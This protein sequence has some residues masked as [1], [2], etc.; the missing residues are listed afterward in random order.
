MYLDESGDHTLA[1]IDPTYPVFVLGGIIVDR[2]YARTVL[3]PRVRAFKA[4]WFGSHSIV[5]HSTDIARARNGFEGLR[6]PSFRREFLA[7]LS[8]LMAELDYLVVACLIHKNKPGI[9]LRDR[10]LNL[11]DDGLHLVV[12]RF[13]LAL[14]EQ[15]DSGLIYAEK[16]RPDLDLALDIAWE[17]LSVRGTYDLNKQRLGLINERIC[18]LS[19][20]AKGVNLAGLQLADLVVSVIGRQASG[21]DTHDNWEIVRSKMWSVNGQIDGYGL[22]TLP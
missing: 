10:A 19:L 15:P 1:K 11:Y 8:S 12:E 9:K 3:E 2:T 21:L 20:K 22:V 4:N 13:C 16:R 18:A 7:A 6:D 5:L 17:R 14:G